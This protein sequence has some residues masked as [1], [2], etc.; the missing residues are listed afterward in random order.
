MESSLSGVEVRPGQHRAG[1]DAGV[2]EV[3]GG[4]RQ[5]GPSLGQGPVAAV[6]TAIARGDAG[7]DV[8]ERAGDRP[9]NSVGDDPGPVHHHDGRLEVRAAARRCRGGSPTPPRGPRRWHCR[10]GRR[11]GQDLASPGP[12]DPPQPGQGHHHEGDLTE[13]GPPAEA[14]GPAP[15]ERDPRHGLFH[16]HHHV[17]EPRRQVLV[18]EV[19]RFT[20][21]GQKND[22][23]GTGAA[24]LVGASNRSQSSTV[25]PSPRVAP[26][27]DGPVATVGEAKK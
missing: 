12:R 16:H 27:L 25:L 18:D 10:R 15:G 19:G 21:S 8:D 2:D 1:V 11:P 23:P 7:V 26:R 17:G 22:A 14:P 5:V 20:R 13:D 6:D 3:D 9:E 24:V 4:A